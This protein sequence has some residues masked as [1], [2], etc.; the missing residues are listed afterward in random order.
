[1]SGLTTFLESQSDFQAV[2]SALSWL[3]AMRVRHRIQG[4]PAPWLDAGFAC[5]SLGALAR[6]FPQWG[7]AGAVQLFHLASLLGGLLLARSIGAGSKPTLVR[8]LWIALVAAGIAS[9]WWPGWEPLRGLGLAFACMGFLAGKALRHRRGTDR[10]DSFLPGVLLALGFG[11]GPV[12]GA[13]CTLAGA[14]LLVALD[15]WCTARENRSSGWVLRGILVGLTSVALM[16]GGWGAA[17]WRGMQKAADLKGMVREQARQIADATPMRWSKALKFD[18]ADLGTPVEQEFRRALVATSRATGKSIVYTMRRVGEEIRFGPESIEPG[19]SLASVPGDPYQ[20]PPAELSRVWLDRHPR[21]AGPYQ[22]EFGRFV[23][24]FAPV[25]DPGTGEVLL[26]VGVDLTLV[27]WNSDL[28]R[29]RLPPLLLALLGVVLLQWGLP[30][31]RSTPRPGRQRF[32]GRR[33]SI[34]VGLAGGIAT[35]AFA[36]LVD[37]GERLEGRRPVRLEA[38]QLARRIGDRMSRLESELEA[39]ARALRE[40]PGSFGSLAP[41]LLRPDWLQ[42]VALFTDSV[43]QSLGKPVGREAMDTGLPRGR[44]AAES[45]SASFQMRLPVGLR[46]DQVAATFEPRKVLGRILSRSV[47]SNTCIELTDRTDPLPRLVIPMPASCRS[48]TLATLPIYA[49][50]RTFILEAK[51]SS[52]SGQAPW[53]ARL[54]ILIL[55]GGGGLSAMA[56]VVVASLQRRELYLEGQVQERTGELARSEERWRFALEAAGDGL[57][58][59]NVATGLAFYSGRWIETLGMSDQDLSGTIDDW[60]SRLHPEDRQRVLADLDRHLAGRAPTWQSEHRMRRRDGT[61]IWVMDRG[62]VVERSGDGAPLRMIAT[63]TDV[64]QRRR[65]IEGVIERDRLLRGL[66]EMSRALLSENEQE[67]GL[68]DALRELGTATK[69][70]RAYIFE[71]DVGEDGD[72]VSSIQHEWCNAGIESL[73]ADPELHEMSY[74]PYGPWFLQTLRAGRPVHGLMDDFPGLFQESM[75]RQG[76][77]SLAMVPIQVD[78]DLWG[79]LGLDDCT[80]DR[81]WSDAELDLLGTAGALIGTGIRRARSRRELETLTRHAQDLAEQAQEA[82]AAKSQFL[83]NMS[84]EIRTPMNGVL[85]M[86]GLLLDTRLDAEQRQWADI[87]QSSAENLL[88]IINDILD[89]SKIE[90]GKMDIEEIEFDLAT[91][92]DETL[93][94]LSSRSQQ[95]GLELT[96]L[97]DPDVPVWVRGDPGRIRQIVLNLAGN[98]LKFTEHGEVAVHVQRVEEDDATAVLKFS[99]RDTGIGIPPDRLE[100]LF[101]PFTQVDGSTTRKYG[102]TGLGLAICRQLAE[103]MGGETGVE[104]E[105]GKGSVFWFTVRIQKVDRPP[106]SALADLEGIRALVVDDHETNRILMRTLLQGWGAHCVEVSDGNQAVE[107]IAAARREGLPFDV[108]ILDYQMPGMD[109]EELGRRILGDPDLRD[110]PLVMMSSLVRRGDAQ[111]MRGIGFAAYLTKPVRQKQVRECLEIVLGRSSSIEDPALVTEHTVREAER[112]KLRILLAED[113]VVNQKVAQGLLRRLGQTADIVENGML[114]LDALRE[115]PYDLLLLDCQM[116][117]M[118]GFETVRALRKPDSG[119]L[120]KRI[121]VVAMTANAMKGDRERCLEAGMDDYIAKPIVASELE[122]ALRKWAGLF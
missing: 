71:N 105:L 41:P 31:R 38:E 109:G 122:A 28:A 7:P 66:L 2:V 13:I 17:Q 119:V 78:D 72:L 95:K 6:V 42:G 46:H 39:L 80:K 76:I 89:F 56:A 74:E 68:Q 18:S 11:L 10:V 69:A 65:S 55:V 106:P 16:V 116:P 53:W 101:H 85:G 51:S 114:A 12:Q 30:L 32:Q 19:T 113:N 25:T 36:W 103:L 94:M 97:V 57:W 15:L 48:E 67:K 54:S 64:D 83:A 102:G 107:A 81:E 9:T 47:G 86:I 79:F 118:D 33:E 82:S 61:W 27:H 110:L 35:L 59:W 37:E 3:L 23:S 112:R 1:M 4:Q 115:K 70:D 62:R 100:A 91:T 98:S 120:D 93:G 121:P 14:L 90:A 21:S 87:V 49:F 26:V 24:G 84:H 104:S 44:W 96:C 58:D 20:K 108:A 63:Q 40:A 60:R 8:G 22:D 88:G 43:D 5:L 92:M 111:R 52:A 29:A 34:L 45:D 99:I 117:V 50:G 75:R 77:R 73:I